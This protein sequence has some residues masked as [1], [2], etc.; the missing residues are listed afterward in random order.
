LPHLALS[1]FSSTLIGGRWEGRQRQRLPEQHLRS[2]IS[3]RER[4]EFPDHP[5]VVSHSVLNWDEPRRYVRRPI[6]VA[7]RSQQIRKASHE[8]R[9]VFLTANLVGAKLLSF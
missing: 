1:I 9:V 5:E 3:A 7:K 4:P 2:S 6:G 8:A